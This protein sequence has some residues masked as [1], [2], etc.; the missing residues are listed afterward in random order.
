VGM[1]IRPLWAV[2][3]LSWLPSVVLAS[4]LG[5]NQ[6]LSSNSVVVSG[7]SSNYGGGGLD[8]SYGG[9]KAIDGSDSTEWS[10]NG[11]GDSAWIS[12]DFPATWTVVGVGL[13]TRT[14]TTSAQISQFR[15]LDASGTSLGTFDIPDATQLYSF[16]LTNS[17]TT[18]G[19]KFEVVASSGGN[20]GA[21]TIAVYTSSTTTTTAGSTTV[22][23]TTAPTTT[24]NTAADTTASDNGN[25]TTTITVTTATTSLGGA[26]Q[27]SSSSTIATSSPSTDTMATTQATTTAPSS[28]TASPPAATTFFTSS[29]VTVQADPSI[30]G[31]YSIM[32]DTPNPV[33]C[34]ALC[35]SPPTAPFTLHAMA[36]TSAANNHSL[37]LGPY[38]SDVECTLTAFLADAR[39]FR[40][41]TYS[42]SPT[43]TPVLNVTG[44]ATTLTP[45][46]AIVQSS[47][48]GMM[49]GGSV[50]GILAAPV[51]VSLVSANGVT[52][53]VNTTSP[54]VSALRVWKAN[55]M[56]G[57]SQ[58][59]PLH[60]TGITSHQL[61]V[62]GLDA[63]TA[64]NVDC[65]LI[66]ASGGVY[67]TDSA[68]FT[69]LSSSGEQLGGNVA[70]SSLGAVVSGF[71]SE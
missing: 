1:P 61:V 11:D 46:A 69:T 29:G 57:A 71:S 3:V 25:S 23:T 63:D 60:T 50:S 67:R 62:L 16:S 54:T 52:V 9:N 44:F 48:G 26:A 42:W 14:M 53:W 15:V 22:P 13:W 33:L 6:A 58:L 12:L 5:S 45:T 19:V 20:T 56:S 41:A 4:S 8:S 35:R 39:V 51:S 30:A 36:M 70:L 32:L 47:G 34:G 68:A 28:P 55:G 31:G 17:V 38:T 65:L 10:S 49:M 24:A 43:T 18:T 40:S 37:P 64:Y 66:D 21:K 2:S 7:V 59:R 27:S